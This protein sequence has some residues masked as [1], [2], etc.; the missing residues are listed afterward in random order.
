MKSRRVTI[1]CVAMIALAGTPR[2]WQEAGKLLNIVQHKAQVKF[3]SM[4]LPGDRESAKTE[5]IAAAEVPE[6]EL[7]DDASTCPPASV[8][9]WKNRAPGSSKAN[10]MIAR[11]F[12]QAKARAQRQT[13]SA[14]AS[15]AGVIAKA[16]KAPRV[17]ESVESLLRSRKVWESLS[18]AVALNAPVPLVMPNVATAPLPQPASTSD[19]FRYVLIPPT[20]PV[21]ASL[22][23]KE[24][25]LHFKLM[26]KSIEDRKLLR[27]KGR[28]PVSNGFTAFPS[29]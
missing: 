5:L 20:Y 29:S 12:V 14:P 1:F 18:P 16:L 7:A 15:H 22:V 28:L 2:A 26:K 27:Q 25:V 10:R 13:D 17:N 11:A 23:E 4:V 6:G 24:A 21:A 9:S 19:T 8:K 3:W